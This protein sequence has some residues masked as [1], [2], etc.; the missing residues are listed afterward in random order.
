MKTIFEQSK[1]PNGFFDVRMDCGFITAELWIQLD[2]RSLIH[3]PS[4]CAIWTGEN[5]WEKFEANVPKLFY[6]VNSNFA[7]KV[8]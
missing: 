7:Q 2:F 1:V 8:E 4:S 3:P 5:F 6:G